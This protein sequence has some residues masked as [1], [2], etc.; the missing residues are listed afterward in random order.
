MKKHL[1]YATL[2]ASSLLALSACSDEVE[3]VITPE[4]VGEKTPIELSVGIA[5]QGFSNTL[6]RAVVTDGSGKTKRAFTSA[7]NLFFVVKAED[8]NSTS[9]H[10]KGAD[11]WG[12]NYA[13]AA[14]V[15]NP[16]ADSK[17]DVTFHDNYL[18]WDDAYARD[19]KVS[20]YSIA[21][22][23]KQRTEA[24]SIGSQ[25]K[26]SGSFGNS[27]TPKIAFTT[28]AKDLK[29]TWSIGTQ[30]AQNATTFANDDLVFSNNVAKRSDTDDKRLYFHIDTK[31]FDTGKLIYYHA[32][33]KLTI[34]IKAGDGFTAS[35]QS[36]DFKFTTADGTACNN[37]D[38][39]FC[40]N[41][42]Y[43]KDCQFD[44]A[45]GEFESLAVSNVQN[46]SS[47][48]LASTT[49]R[50]AAQG[51]F[52]T[53]TAFVVPGTDMT[54]NDKTDMFSFIIDGNKYDISKQAL[55]EAIKNK[56]T[57][58]TWDNSS[59][60]GQTVKTTVLGGGKTLLAGVNYEFTFTVGKTAIKDMSAQV[61]DWENVTAAEV[62]PSNA[63]TLSFTLET[64]AGITPVA[65]LDLYRSAV[66]SATAPTTA[67]DYATGYTST[68]NKA[69][70]T[71]IGETSVYK[72]VDASDNKQWYWP[73][74]RTY[75]HF[76]TISPKTTSV[77]SNNSVDEISLSSGAIATTN[78]YVWG[79]PLLEKH[80][81]GADHNVFAYDASSGYTE[82]LAP[83]IGATQDN[84]R[85]TQFHM[86]S[87]IFV[88]LETTDGDD[89]VTITG[90]TV[91]LL[92]YAKNAKL[93]VG[94]GLVTGWS[95]YDG[96]GT[97]MTSQTV[98]AT[99]TTPAYDYSYR[100]VP[101]S[102]TYTQSGTTVTVG[103]EITTTD[104]NVY[105]IND[106]ST[107]KINGTSNAISRWEPGKNYYYKFKLKKTG[108]ESLSATIVQWVNISAEEDEIVIQ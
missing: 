6:T 40:L 57:G 73:D 31:K 74:N 39:S 14:A 11:K 30:G 5:D 51:E 52:Y 70:L 80:T 44:I 76:R 60:N 54:A 38:N 21:V 18:Y 33:T 68:G 55:Y 56:K 65:E 69:S 61:V 64:T 16:A 72:A 26:S 29:T 100:V 46:Y 88:V 43:G 12:Y 37:P 97:A 35:A 96:T 53:L 63:S 98:A 102:L 62:T 103:L 45:N 20:I 13:T 90:A 3:T 104:G 24:V 99:S 107:Q 101:Q 78:D 87:N 49:R 36:A 66:T 42:F 75:Y 83:A 47:I 86:M 32:L 85:I 106:L 94:N 93:Q 82:Y 91:K 19:T 89:K 34:K 17:S 1:L 50:P 7:T 79:A 77:T 108:I 9:G 67:T 48:N 95:D 59:D 2:Y 71:K 28:D 4:P 25:G 58:E 84:I 23:N 15:S 105:K 10:T 22:A 8:G 27:T 92:R 81:E 41:G